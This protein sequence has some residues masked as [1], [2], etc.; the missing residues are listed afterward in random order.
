MRGRGGFI[1]EDHKETKDSQRG[2][3][4]PGPRAAITVVLL[5]VLLD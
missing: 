1:D 5:V 4:L 3:L 2:V